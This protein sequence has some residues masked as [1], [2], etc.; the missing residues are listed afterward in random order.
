MFLAVGIAESSSSKRMGFDDKNVEGK[1]GAAA[2]S[3]GNKGIIVGDSDPEIENETVGNNNDNRVSRQMSESSIYTTDQEEDDDET[4][5][6]IELGPQCTLKEQFEKD[7]VYYSLLTFHCSSFFSYL[8]P[9]THSGDK[10]MDRWKEITSCLIF[11]IVFDNRGIGISLRP[12][13]LVLGDLLPPR[14]EEIT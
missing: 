8:L 7:K 1:V 6:K 11:M 10:A 12:P 5:N 4:N 9:P 14:W 13:R 2:N 3:E